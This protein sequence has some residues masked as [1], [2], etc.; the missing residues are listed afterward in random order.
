MLKW[1]ILL[2]KMTSLPLKNMTYLIKIVI[3]PMQQ[4]AKKE[5]ICVIQKKIIRKNIFILEKY[6]LVLEDY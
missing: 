5:K 3:F 2:T 1:H 6:F 4:S